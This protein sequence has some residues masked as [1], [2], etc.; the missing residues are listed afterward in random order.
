MSRNSVQASPSKLLPKVRKPDDLK[1]FNHEQLDRLAKEIRAKIISGVKK[2]GGHLGS[3]LGTVEL[4]LA[5]HRVFDSPHDTIIF[6]TGHQ[7]YTHKLITGRQDFRHLRTAQGLSGYPS[8]QESLHDVLENSH[9][10]SSLGWADGIAKANL[11]NHSDAHTVVVIGDGALTGGPVWEAIN[12][13]AQSMNERLTIIIND[14]GMS[15]TPTKGGMAR[16]LQTVK[17][18]EQW[19]ALSTTS[20]RALYHLGKP[21]RLIRGFIHKLKSFFVRVVNIGGVFKDYDI[22]YL[23]PIDGH[24]IEF[25]EKELRSAKRLHEPSIVHVVTQKGH[26]VQVAEHDN[27]GAYHAVAANYDQDIPALNTWTEV[28]RQEMVKLG[29]QYPKLVTITAAMTGP[30]GLDLFRNVFPKRFFDVGI[31]EAEAFTMAAGLAYKGFHPLIALYSTFALRGFDQLLMDVALHNQSLTLILDRAGVTGDDG[32]S[33]NGIWDMALFS[34]IPNVRIATPYDAKSLKR[35]LLEAVST[36]GVN[37]VRYPKGAI[38][39]QLSI[40]QSA[41]RQKCVLALGPLL[42]SVLANPFYQDFDIIAP[43][44]PWPLTSELL[45]QLQPYDYILTLEDGVLHGGLGEQ[46]QVACPHKT[47]EI[48]AIPNAFLPTDSRSSLLKIYGL[49]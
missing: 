37:I 38:P 36:Q 8:R 47:V 29:K 34:K 9:A 35:A 24:N 44:W 43:L 20:K 17:V 10:S 7:T 49:A 18:S 12:N 13:I 6:D 16:Y 45:D 1:Q 5:I 48:R 21:G 23:G 26:G 22:T 27:S 4:T 39:A 46:I 28:F 14:N 33:H 25:I 11:L 30:V 2:N 19:N 41:G 40:P 32:A 42:E 15:Y 31:A 3:N